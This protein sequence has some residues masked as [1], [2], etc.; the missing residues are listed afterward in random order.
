V[1]RAQWA[2]GVPI[3]LAVARWRF[4][5]LRRVD[6][7]PFELAVPPAVAPVMLWSESWPGGLNQAAGLI[8]VA[9]SYG[10]PM[11]LDGPFI[12]VVTCFSER[13]PGGSSPEV[14]IAGAEHRDAAWAR[15]DWD[16]ADEFD[17]DPDEV[18][19]QPGFVRTER[20]VTVDREQQMILA[21]SRHGYEALRFRRGPVVVTAVARH[22]FPGVPSFR[23]AD[24]LEPYFAGYRRF[25][26]GLLRFWNL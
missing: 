15:Q 6:P 24:D 18:I 25:V 2:A 10:R 22:G 13:N 11:V 20:L 1:L 26:H 16:V 8:S 7:H 9:L 3:A 14:A 17:P 23:P 19:S 21:V 4:A 12:E 5:R